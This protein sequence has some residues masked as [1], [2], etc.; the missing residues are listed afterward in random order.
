M[1]NTT[2]WKIKTYNT[3][4]SKLKFI[5]KIKIKNNEKIYDTKR[6]NKSSFRKDRKFF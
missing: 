1:P 5:K 6:L 4:I 3:N 2:I